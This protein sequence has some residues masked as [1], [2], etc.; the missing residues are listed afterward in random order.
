MKTTITIMIIVITISTELFAQNTDKIYKEMHGTITISGAWALY[1]MTV[2]WAEEFQKIFPNIRIDIGA[3]GAGKGM[4]DCLS[5][6]VDIGMISRD[7]YEQEIVKGAWWVSVTKDAVV[8]TVNVLNPVLNDIMKNG[9][10][11]ETLVG[12]WVTGDINKWG[13]VVNTN[14]K[15][16]INVYTRSDA[17]GAAETWALYLGY[18]QPDLMNIGVYGDPGLAAAVKNDAWGIGYNNINYVYNAKTKEMIDGI[19]IIPI[20]LNNNGKIDKEENFYDTRDD[21]IDAIAKGLYP[22]PPARDLHFATHGKPKNKIVT[23]FIKWVLTEGQVYIPESGYIN[24][25]DEKIN[26]ELLKLE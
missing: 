18:H 23:A 8:P 7:I 15:Y 16:K 2:K 5:E 13:Q 6:V 3:G 22:S 12:I 17:C 4:V 20:D 24:L 25:T 9:V 21:L 1:P 11:Q 14:T 10:K 19:R 26:E